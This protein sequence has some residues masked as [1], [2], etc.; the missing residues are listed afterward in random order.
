[1]TKK[2][3][4][5]SFSVHIDEDKDILEILEA[6]KDNKSGFIRQ[7]IRYY[8]GL[9]TENDENVDKVHY[10]VAQLEKR[11]NDLIKWHEE[12]VQEVLD[13]VNSKV[14][15]FAGELDQLKRELSILKQ[16]IEKQKVK[17]EQQKKDIKLE[18]TRGDEVVGYY[19]RNGRRFP[20]TAER[21]KAY[22]DFITKHYEQFKRHPEMMIRRFR[23]VH[24]WHNEGI[25]AF[26]VKKYFPELEIDVKDY[27]VVMNV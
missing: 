17:E 8:A 2:T 26:V 10:R 15:E 24:G 19:I 5:I 25:L 16:S 6:H 14:T 18:E 21:A 20:I 3:I 13:Y 27:E 22:L 7:A 1:M 4:S 11:L 12:F 23:D 9:I